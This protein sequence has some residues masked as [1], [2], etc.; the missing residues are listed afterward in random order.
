MVASMQAMIDIHSHVVWGLDDGATDIEQSLS[1]LRAAAAGGTTDIVATPHSNA[2]F[3]YQ[4]EL[5]DERIRE[6]ASRTGWQTANSPGMRSSPERRQYRRSAAAARQ[7]L[8]QRQAV[9]T[10]GM[11]GFPRG[12]AH[13][14][15][16]AAADRV[17]D[18]AGGDASGAESGAAAETRPGGR[19][20]GTGLPGAGDCALR[21]AVVSAE[22][23]ALTA[24]AIVGARAGTRGRERCARSGAS[25]CA[26]GRSIRGGAGH[27]IGEEEADILF[28]QNPQAIIDG[29]ATVRGKTDS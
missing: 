3:A 4:A 6:L 23:P 21:L 26:P 24:T 22:R 19:M 15:G 13:G 25:A 5:L 28:T 1:M 12:E 20:G 17:R 10:G 7:V 29:A 2:A 18:R 14:K 16:I 8:D 11:P 9:S 27:G